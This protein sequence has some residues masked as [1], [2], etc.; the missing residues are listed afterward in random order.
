MSSGFGLFWRSESITKTIT[1][2]KKKINQ[3]ASSE[4]SSLEK[5][6]SLYVLLLFENIFCSTLDFNGALC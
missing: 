5:N 3:T 2:K 6:K 4:L 1:V